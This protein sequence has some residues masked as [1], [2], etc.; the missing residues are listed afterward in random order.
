[1][2]EDAALLRAAGMS[3]HEAD[4]KRVLFDRCEAALGAPRSLAFFVPGRIEVL[5][6]HTDYAGGRSLLCAM[7]RG[8]AVAAAPRTDDRV[9]VVDAM[10][11]ETRELAMDPALDAER[12]DWSNYV[13]A[14]ARSMA[15]H[16][17]GARRGADIAFAS[18]L[19][20]ASGMSSSSALIIALFMVLR[21]VNELE[22]DPVYR[23]VIRSREML[24]EYL[25]AVENGRSF[26]PFAGD[27]GVGTLGGSQDQTAIL[28][29]GTG[30]LSQYAWCPARAEGEIPLSAGVV[31]VL[32]YSG[33]SAEKT[34]RALEL[35]NA[36]SF[37]A[38]KIVDLWNASKGRADQTLAD[39]VASSSQAAKEIRALLSSESGRLRDR[40]EQFLCETYEIVPRAADAMAGGDVAAFGAQVARSQLGAE[41]LLGNQI[42]ETIA[43]VRL[44]RE[45][46]AAAASAFGAGF[47]GSVW[48]LVRADGA[49]NFLH[50]WR[51]AYLAAF[52]E[53]AANAEF[54]LTAPGPGA[55]RL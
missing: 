15:R 6:K 32:A 43:L 30:I 27:H 53:A 20:P 48:A 39:A 23:Q 49:G 31:F 44:A 50:E 8:F 4:A 42:E 36:V 29:C 16:F 18:D 22:H 10:R 17:P 45:H 12:G 41:K 13:A 2:N 3:A 24:G 5:G 38:V 14:V 54:F 51:D 55:L 7:E 21:A 26:G 11:N 1:M 40:F 25:G 19:P 46:G 34:V 47:G 28:C 33:V 37:A 35:Y 9:R 52:P